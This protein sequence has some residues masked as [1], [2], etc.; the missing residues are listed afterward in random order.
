MAKKILTSPQETSSVKAGSAER[1]QLRLDVQ[2][3]LKENPSLTA[4]EIGKLVKV[5]PA[6]DLKSK[7]WSVFVSNQRKKILGGGRRA[8]RQAVS[9]LSQYVIGRQLSEV[10][11]GADVADKFITTLSQAG[12]FA[13]AKFAIQKWKGLVESVGVDVAQ[14]VIEQMT[15]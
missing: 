5:E 14:K 8:N 9:E 3:A 7:R 15:K 1:K 6:I 4:E 10:A 13:D 2:A 12:S 11:G